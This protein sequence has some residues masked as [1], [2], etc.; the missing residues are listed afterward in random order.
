[1]GGKWM[2]RGVGGGDVRSRDAARL[3]QRDHQS[4]MVADRAGICLVQLTNTGIKGV[5]KEAD[6]PGSRHSRSVVHDCRRRRSTKDTR[7]NVSSLRRCESM[8]G[9]PHTPTHGEQ[10]PSPYVKCT[11]TGRQ[12]GSRDCSGLGLPAW[13]SAIGTTN[14][15]LKS[16][17]AEWSGDGNGGTK[18]RCR[19]TH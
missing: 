18:L 19:T 12:E 7:P 8:S 14:S 17:I 10:R 3:Q 16:M 1:M 2:V 15:F 13:Y 4:D 11:L 5:L 6:I 9:P